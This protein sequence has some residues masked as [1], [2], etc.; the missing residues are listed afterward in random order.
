MRKWLNRRNRRLEIPIINPRVSDGL[1]INIFSW[2]QG[3]THQHWIDLL[4][5]ACTSRPHLLLFATAECGGVLPNIT[6]QVNL[7]SSWT[8]R[9]NDRLIEDFHLVCNSRRQGIVISVW[10]SNQNYRLMESS[11]MDLTWDSS[12]RK[13][14]VFVQ[15]SF[16]DIIFSFVAVHFDAVRLKERTR[17]LRKV[18]EGVS[19]FKHESDVII[20]VGDMNFRIDQ[21]RRA[22]CNATRLGAS[23]SLLAGDQLFKLLKIHTHWLAGWREAAEPSFLP[24]YKLKTI[25]KGYDF[26][27]GRL[28]AFTDRILIRSDTR[29]VVHTLEYT[30]METNGGSD[31]SPIFARIMITDC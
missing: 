31:H 27:S 7:V 12:G 15:F 3:G 19:S 9:L 24:T 22:V 26:A 6:G 16:M 2:N 5:K 18:L 30:R 21:E 20:V 23:D 17:Q 28:P 29:L 14:G 11:H 13:A 8:R 1:L 4:D 10:A 25:G